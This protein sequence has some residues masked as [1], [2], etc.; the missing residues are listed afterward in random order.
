MFNWL[1]K[2]SKYITFAVFLLFIG[3]EVYL[4]V[5]MH[6]HVIIHHYPLIYAPDS[7]YGYRGIPNIEGYIRRP[8][9]EKRYKLNNFGY[10]GP[11]FSADHPDSI[12]RILVGGS[13]IVEG[14]WAKQKESY[15]ALLSRLFKERGYKVEVINCGI[16]GS[17]REWQDINLLKEATVRFHANLALFER[18]FPI[19]HTNYLRE[20]YKG[21]SMLFTGSTAEE[22]LASEMTAKRKVDWLKDNSFITK[23]FELSYYM[24]YLTRDQPDNQWGSLWDRWSDYSTNST[25]SW[26][27]YEDR[28]LTVEESIHFLNGMSD[29]MNKTGCKLIA[30]EYGNNE[31]S[32]RIRN[33]GYITFPY[34]SLDL[35]LDEKKYQ[36][37][38]DDHLNELGFL[39]TAEKLF[40]ELSRNYIPDAYKPNNLN[41]LTFNR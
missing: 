38:L 15:P 22:R 28:S 40:D 19:R 11:D 5:V 1:L 4:R 23:I 26:Q 32:D 3:S 37:E 10:Y 39:I 31:M 27:N 9:I 34:L 12:F 8:S 29:E 30:Y 20:T 35:P 7:V 17:M 36:H 2:I 21:Y 18:P 24:R 6:E 13:S 25:Q 14:I 16:S 41:T 33:G